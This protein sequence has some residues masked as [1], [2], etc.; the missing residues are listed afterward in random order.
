MIKIR[1][2]CQQKTPQTNLKKKK[3][4]CSP[5]ENISNSFMSRITVRK[6][7]QF[8]RKVVKEMKASTKEETQKINR[9]KTDA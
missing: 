2:F 8:N 5:E 7:K 1:N 3:K 9:N 4:S 6:Y